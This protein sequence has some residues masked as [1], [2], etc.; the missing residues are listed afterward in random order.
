MPK[1]AKTEAVEM[2]DHL[3]MLRVQ[4]DDLI[5]LANEVAVL[6]RQVAELERL[7]KGESK[8]RR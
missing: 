1:G 6:R 3:V 7:V 2:A 5:K 8:R 4:R